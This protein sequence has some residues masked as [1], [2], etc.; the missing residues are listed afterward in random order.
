AQAIDHPAREG[1]R[2]GESPP[3]GAL[4]DVAL[5]ALGMRPRFALVLDGHELV[6]ARGGISATLSTLRNLVAD[7][8]HDPERAF[9][10]ALLDLRHGL[11]VVR[12]L[13]E[14]ARL[15]GL[16]ALI[17]WCDDWLAARRTLVARVEAQLA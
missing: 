1:H 16:F 7:R 8:V 12:V 2:I 5:H 14:V 15:E 10:A 4:R 11:D 6:A 13:R 17:R 3:V 9:R